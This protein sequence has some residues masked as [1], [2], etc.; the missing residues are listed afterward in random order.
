MAN[1]NPFKIIGITPN[2][3]YGLTD[4]EVLSLVRDVVKAQQKKVHPDVIGSSRLARRSTTIN[5]AL[6][7]LENCGREK[8]AQLRAQFVS[9]TPLKRTLEKVE[10]ALQESQ[11]KLVQTGAQMAELFSRQLDMAVE[12]DEM[13]DICIHNPWLSNGQSYL[14]S[15]LVNPRLFFCKVIIDQAWNILFYDDAAVPV[16]KKTIIGSID[17]K[18]YLNDELAFKIRKYYEKSD[19]KKRQGVAYQKILRSTKTIYRGPRIIP[20]DLHLIAKD[21]RLGVYDNGY[22]V[23][24]N[25][26]HDGSIFFQ[27]EGCVKTCASLLVE[28]EV[29]EA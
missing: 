28:K 13:A 24:A 9:T 25:R 6:N 20:H 5:S 22:I 26:A 23:T 18:T 12:H 29:L 8:F 16:G 3:I 4:K 11:E 27:I 10:N 14:A 7:T 1:T 17:T 2:A 15:R 19:M 21:I